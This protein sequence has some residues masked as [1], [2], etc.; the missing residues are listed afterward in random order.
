M[1]IL[2]IDTSC[3]ETAASILEDGKILSNIIHSQIIHKKYGGVV[4]DIASKNHEENISFVVKASLKKAK[5]KFSDISAIAVTYCP[6]LMSSLLVGLNY[7]KGLSLGLNIPLIPINHL[8]GHLCSNL[9]NKTNVKY[10]YISLLVSGGHTQIWYVENYKKYQIIS[11]TVDDAA[12]EAFDK[13][14]KMLGL[15]YPG[16]PEIERK[17]IG[18]NPKKYQFTI[19]KMK[20]KPLNFSF[21]GIKTSLYYKI[22]KMNKVEIENNLHHL[23]ASYQEVIIDTLLSRLKNVVKTY[24]VDNISIV[25]GVSVNKRFRE[26]SKH[27]EKIFTLQ[28]FFPDLEYCTDNGAMIAM[29]GYI[30]YINNDVGFNQL[31]VTPIPNINF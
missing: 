15:D 21:S 27:L 24:K 26:K 13:G 14:A 7:A 5:I 1:I 22:I 31:H 11:T 6:G 30:K 29:A 8:E 4:P 2:G 19:P 16:G 9:I 18:G 20:N 25:G 17:S 3:D 10:P 12:G 23:C 28:I